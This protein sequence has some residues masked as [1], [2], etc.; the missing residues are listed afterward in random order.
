MFLVPWE[1]RQNFM[2]PATCFGP[3]ASP[4]WSLQV[5]SL[6]HF[7]LSNSI[8]QPRSSPTYPDLPSR[9][10]TKPDCSRWWLR[11]ALPRGSLRT[12]SSLVQ[13]TACHLFGAKPLTQQ[14]LNNWHLDPWEQISVKFLIKKK[15]F[16]LM[17]I[18]LKLSYA[19]NGTHYIQVSIC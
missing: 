15:T 6:W 4:Y 9:I 17:K 10:P 18:A 7:D 16:S 13:V 11:S 14:M 5:H 2:I 3:T 1:W 19:K 8:R 12:M